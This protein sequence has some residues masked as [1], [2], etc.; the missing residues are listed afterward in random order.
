MHGKYN[1]YLYGIFGIATLLIAAF[2]GHD[3]FGENGVLWLTGSRVTDESLYFFTIFTRP[4][5]NGGSG[6]PFTIYEEG[7]CGSANSGWVSYGH[8]PTDYDLDGRSTESK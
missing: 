6:W 7:W 4:P 8:L 1:V 5:L 2:F 3:Y